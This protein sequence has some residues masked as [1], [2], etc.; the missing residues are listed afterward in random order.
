MA[1]LGYVGARLRLP[2]RVVLPLV[3]VGLAAAG[4][5][6]VGMAGVSAARGYL[7]RQVDKK[8][9]AC[10]AG[11][12]GHP[13]VAA[14]G[15]GPVAGQAP[16]DTCDVELL[17]PGGQLLTTAASGAADGPALQVGGSWLAAHLGRPVTMPGTGTGGG[18][19]VIVEAV[20]YQP[21]RILYVYGPDDV[22]Y[23]IGGRTGHGPAG[24]LVI[25]TGL[26][27][28][29]QLTGRV[30]DGYAAAAGAVLVV[31]AGAALAVVRA[32]LRPLGRA[33][34]LAEV[35]A[36]A[37]GGQPQLMSRP[38]VQASGVPSPWLTG[39]TRGI[40]EQIG[41]SR[42]A[43]AA[44]HR[45]A[46][47]MAGHL[48]EVAMELRT[49]VNVVRGF[50]E[51][52]RQRDARRSAGLDRMMERVADEVARMDTLTQRLDT[53]SPSRPAG[54]DPLAVRRSGR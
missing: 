5:S 12:P 43:E 7:M 11:L 37:A 52:Y 13:V 16:P 15:S 33:A 50:A 32:L 42:A 20:H 54:T 19:R 28:I 31:L 23:V 21:Q 46:G 1:R 35:T 30:A 38:G 48:D 10:A 36:H 17:S 25:M 8:L 47:E 26:A 6:A 27:G 49:S 22:M 3:A 29:G 24:L 9:V 14:P 4:A 18:W 44:A 41:A 53:S 39:L 51:Y 2:L 45:S 34:R 40:A